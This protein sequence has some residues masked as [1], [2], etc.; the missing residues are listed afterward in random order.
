MWRAVTSLIYFAVIE[1]HQVDRVVPQL[2]GVQHIP[3]DALNVDWLHAKD[4]RGGDR[5]F[6]HYYRAWHEPGGCIRGSER[7]PDTSGSISERIHP[8]PTQIT[9]T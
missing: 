3:E 5:W 9:A 2:G 4:G 6:P 7:H 8:G 1:W